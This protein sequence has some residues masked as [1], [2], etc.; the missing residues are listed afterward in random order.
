[1]TKKVDTND[2]GYWIVKSLERGEK[3]SSKNKK[4]NSVN[5]IIDKTNL[6][7]IDFFAKKFGYSR[8]YILS[9][10]I[11]TEVSS[12]FKSLDT[13]DKFILASNVDKQISDMDDVEHDYK[14]ETWMHEVKEVPSEVYYPENKSILEMNENEKENNE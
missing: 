12:M 10:L 5:I 6:E 11:N 4:N 13:K 7:I 14:N 9:N 8:S 3:L 2:L 1:M